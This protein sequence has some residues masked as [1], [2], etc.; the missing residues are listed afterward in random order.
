MF[1][2]MHSLKSIHPAGICISHIN[3][4]KSLPS[5]SFIS[6]RISVSEEVFQLWKFQLGKKNMKPWQYET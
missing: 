4:C 5:F 3:F 2:L 6:G 1:T